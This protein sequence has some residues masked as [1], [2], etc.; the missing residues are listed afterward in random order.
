MSTSRSAIRMNTRI[1]G[2]LICRRCAELCVALGIGIV[3][4]LPDV[5][6]ARTAIDSRTP[7][8]CAPTS[9]PTVARTE[10]SCTGDC[11]GDRS[12]SVNELVY[13]VN[14]ALGNP[15]PTLCPGF[16]QTVRIDTLLTAVIN[17][18]TGCITSTTYDL[19]EF[20]MFTFQREAGFGFCPRVGSLY[21]ADLQRLRSGAYRLGSVVLVAGDPEIDDCLEGFIDLDGT[22]PCA[23]PRRQPCRLLTDA[24]RES[25][26]TAFAAVTAYTGP[27]RFCSH[28]AYDPCVINAIEWDLGGPGSRFRATDYPCT[29][30][31][32]LEAAE[33]DRITALLESL[34]SGAA[35]ECPDVG[36]E[37]CG[38][39]IVEGG[40][41]CD[42][43]N[44]A[45]G[46]GCAANCTEE[47]ERRCDFH[48]P[49][50]GVTVQLRNLLIDLSRGLHGTQTFTTG[51]PRDRFVIAPDG[52]VVSRPGDIPVVVKAAEFQGRHFLPPRGVR[53]RSGGGVS[54]SFQRMYGFSFSSW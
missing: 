38:N 1:A 49:H 11:N 10:T 53:S 52:E 18:L 45:G 33:I 21:S 43:G 41:G 9:Q 47:I 3:I 12:V 40:E 16:G 25:V 54:G 8:S 23:V 4:S 32:R 39:G 51:A 34:G 35:T 5:A 48:A 29:D 15:G 26:R 44:T 19:S 24:E 30:D 13:G 31:P 6:A 42:D 37:A 20:S 17:A 7:A 50:S 36:G 2:V 28:I 22:T 46:D 14:V 27:E